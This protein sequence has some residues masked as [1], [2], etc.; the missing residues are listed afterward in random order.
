MVSGFTEKVFFIGVHKYGTPF[1]QQFICFDYTFCLYRDGDVV[2]KKFM[3]FRFDPE[4]YAKFKE[5]AKK[6]SLM[7]TEAFERF[8]KACVQIGAVKVP[9]P[10]VERRD[11]EAEVHVLLAWWRKGAYWAHLDGGDEEQSVPGRLLQLLPK[12]RDEVLRNEVEQELKKRFES[13]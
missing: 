7:V 1:P 8:M 11:V 5:L 12:I 2:T 13:D 10:A 9:E 4:L 3:G 6:N